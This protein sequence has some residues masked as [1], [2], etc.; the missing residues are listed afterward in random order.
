MKILVTG[1]FGFIGSH[2]VDVLSKKGYKVIV[3]S[4]SVP[5][6]EKTRARVKFYKVD[7]CSSKINLIFKKEHPD[8]VYHLAA[9]LPK[10]TIEESFYNIKNIKTNI[11]GTLRILEASRNYKIK[12]IIFP[13]S[14]AV[15]GETTI[16]PTPETCTTNQ[17]SL[18]GLAKFSAE[19]L[20]EIYYRLYNIPYIIFRYSNVYG[21]E[22]KPG[23][24]GSFIA[25]F[26]DK[27]S[28]NEQPV[29]SG[30]GK[31]T[32]DCVYIDDVVRANL[33]AIKRDKIGI[34]NVGIGSETSINDIFYKIC[35]I[36]GKKIK[37]KYNL[38][39]EIGIKRN[40]L[41][42]EKIKKELGWQPKT[43][44]DIGLKRTINYF[45]EK[46]LVSENASKKF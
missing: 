25:Y 6:K 28:R 32:R 38:L 34:Y 23:K 14:A 10:S 24:Q 45:L 41:K 18:Y 31:Q 15:Y 12:K 46:N 42:I 2:L 3:L 8:F 4:Q 11:L 7:I 26:V 33:L 37:P 35:Q 21:P 1:G 9:Y 16:I 43:S 27:I 13:S 36:F 39:A 44:L 19:R 5:R 29:I 22:Q 20:F 40:A 30:K 17:I